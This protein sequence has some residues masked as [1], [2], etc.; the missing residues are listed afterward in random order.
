[1]QN[2]G[3][4]GVFHEMLGMAGTAHAGND[5]M[6]EACPEQ[7]RNSLE[8][9]VSELVNVYEVTGLGPLRTRLA[10]AIPMD[11]ELWARREFAL[12]NGVD[13]GVQNGQ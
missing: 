10:V 4:E 13:A 9:G 12:A 2:S 5:F 6:N 11:E 8:E 1:M 3:I 7:A